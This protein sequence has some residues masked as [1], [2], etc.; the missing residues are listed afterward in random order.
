MQPTASSVRI[1]LRH[2]RPP[3]APPPLPVVPRLPANQKAFTL[4][5]VMLAAT[6]LLVSFTGVIQAVT[7]GSEM[8]DTARKQQIAQQ[9][10]EGE[11]TYQR[12]T[13]WATSGSAYGLSSMPDSTFRIKVNDAGTAVIDDTANGYD[14]LLRFGLDDNPALMAAAK[15]FTCQVESGVE[16]GPPSLIGIVWTVTW[17]STAGRVHTRI[18]KGYYSEYGLFMSYRK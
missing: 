17:T 6:V 15:G 16:A 12:T 8:I 4:I 9:I 3:L 2:L 1:Q 10:I 7:I 14:D 18:A 11:M 5:E 13:P